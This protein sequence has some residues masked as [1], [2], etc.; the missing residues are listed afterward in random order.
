MSMNDFEDTAGRQELSALA[1][2]ELDD[3]ASAAACAAWRGDASARRDWHAWHLIGD[4]LRSEDLASDPHADLRFCAAVSIRLASEAVVL[5]PAALATSS[6]GNAR[7]RPGRWMFA[8]AAA[9][10]FVLV[11]GTFAVL[12]TADAPTGVPVALAER[13][14][15]PASTGTLAPT[16]AGATSSLGEAAPP[17]AVVADSR[18][19]RDAQLD[20]YLVAH[21]QF[22]GTSA[23]GVPSVF[24]RSATVDSASR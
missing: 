10:G 13:G 4:V 17:V 6:P 14:V 1:D 9:A 20:R 8:S 7:M 2:G 3:H 18:L 19:I 22:A 24:L 16:N 11:A 15:A 21:K 23:L 5:A 12:R